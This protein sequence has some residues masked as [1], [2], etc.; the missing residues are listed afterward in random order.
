M[1][2]FLALILMLMSIFGYILNIVGFCKADFEAPYKEE[3]FRTIGILT[4]L[5]IVIGYIDFEE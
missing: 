3:V 4:P 5:G 2:R 1:D